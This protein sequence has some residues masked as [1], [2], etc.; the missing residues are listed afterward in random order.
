MTCLKAAMIF[1]CGDGC[2]PVFRLK[3]LKNVDL[4]Y[5]SK[6]SLVELLPVAFQHAVRSV[7][8][9]CR[10]LLVSC[11]IHR[12]NGLENVLC[13]FVIF[14]IYWFLKAPKTSFEISDRRNR[15]PISA[16]LFLSL[17]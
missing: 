7:K 16:N 1:L 6:A 5:G 9:S 8:S 14:L 15:P 3:D 10:T 11:P 13:G 17:G 12:S 4:D 2:H